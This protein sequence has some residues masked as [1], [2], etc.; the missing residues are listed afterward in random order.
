MGVPRDNPPQASCLFL[1]L[2]I[3]AARLAGFLFYMPGSWSLQASLPSQGYQQLQK[4]T[5]PDGLR[6]HAL[7]SQLTSDPRQVLWLPIPSIS[8]WVE[9]GQFN[10]GAQLVL[11]NSPSWRQHGEWKCLPPQGG[12]PI[13]LPLLDHTCL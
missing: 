6:V 8:S 11:N 9:W 12:S 2:D 4:T 10:M 3:L 7:A 1:R 13:K 5:L